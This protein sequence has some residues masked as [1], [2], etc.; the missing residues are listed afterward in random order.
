MDYLILILLITL[1][2]VMALIFFSINKQNKRTN[3]NKN[4]FIDFE[5]IK[6]LKVKRLIDKK[7]HYQI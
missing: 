1:L 7:K 3:D 4:I 6:K 2:V 5:K